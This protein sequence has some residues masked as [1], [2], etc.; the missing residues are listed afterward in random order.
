MQFHL[1]SH[2]RPLLDPALQLKIIDDH[3]WRV[4]WDRTGSFPSDTA[5]L[6]FAL[7]TVILLENRLAGLFCFV[8]TAAVISLPRVI[9]A[10][11][12]P[13]DIMGSLILGPTC[14]LLFSAVPYPRIMFE[15]VLSWF[16]GRMYIVHALLFTFL[17]DA[18]NLFQ[19]L[20]QVGKSLVRMWR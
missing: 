4:I 10:W 20:Q 19:S 13:S 9:F 14:V 12:Y 16:E 17:S 3:R 18:T 1:A 6:F 5:T 2:T 8:W 11:H 15:R 7:A